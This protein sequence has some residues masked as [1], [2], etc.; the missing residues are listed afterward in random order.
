MLLTFTS[1]LNNCCPVVQK[2]LW[3]RRP[4]AS[5][6]KASTSSWVNRAVLT[7]TI[8]CLAGVIRWL[9]YVLCALWEWI[10]SVTTFLVFILNL[11]F[12]CFGA[13]ILLR[14]C[15]KKCIIQRSPKHCEL[16][17]QINTLMQ[18]GRIS[19]YI[20]IKRDIL[21]HQKLGH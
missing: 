20:H 8:F 19:L 15:W 17:Q 1:I 3:E 21:N 6:C 10:N 18:K 14:M 11:E 5:W 9:S 2:W 13:I 7:Q 16:L 4:S 12:P